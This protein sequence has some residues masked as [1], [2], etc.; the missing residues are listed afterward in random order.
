M[1]MGELQ[2]LID[3]ASPDEIQLVV[4]AS[5]SLEDLK[6]VVARYS[7]MKPTAIFFSKLD[8]T[9]RYGQLF[10]LAA[11]TGL[12]LSYFSVGQDVPDDLML[13]HS[14]KLTTMVIEGKLKRG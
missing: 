8:E 2:V 4:S 3:A 9:Y 11:D 13:A 1:Q 7:A 10:S 14:G 12:P 6:E 5:T